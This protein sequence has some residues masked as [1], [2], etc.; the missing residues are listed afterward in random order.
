MPFTDA[1]IAYM[2]SQPLAR[3]ATLSPDGRQPDVVP[4]AF[5]FDGTYFWVGGTGSAVAGTRRFRNVRAGNH[6]VALVIDDLVSLDPFIARGVR[7]YGL[8]ED[9]VER[10][11]MRSWPLYAHHA[12]ALLELKLGGPPRG[13]GVVSVAADGPP[14]RACRLGTVG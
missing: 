7:V 8:A 12:D 3:V 9:P 2:R 11:G 10:V 6:D 5:E 4:L 1:E 14:C 13:Q